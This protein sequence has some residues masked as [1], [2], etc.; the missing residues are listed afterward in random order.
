MVMQRPLTLCSIALLVVVL[1]CSPHSRYEVLLCIAA[2]IG[3]S[4]SNEKASKGLGSQLMAYP[5]LRRAQSTERLSNCLI[6]NE[7]LIIWL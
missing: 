4:N 2:H 7:H 5:P 3:W 1:A 6:I